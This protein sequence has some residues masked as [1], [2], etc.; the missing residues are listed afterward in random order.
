VLNI[1]QSINLSGFFFLFDI[2]SNKK[3]SSRSYYITLYFERLIEIPIP[4]FFPLMY[5]KE[6]VNWFQVSG[7][8]IALILG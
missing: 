6:K 8:T 1:N 5:L 3:F 4:G 7:P 2:K